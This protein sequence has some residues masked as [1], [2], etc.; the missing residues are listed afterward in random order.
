MRWCASHGELYVLGPC[1]SLHY[2]VRIV[3][4]GALPSGQARQ[5]ATTSQGLEDA[6]SQL[7]LSDGAVGENSLVKHYTYRRGVLVILLLMSLALVL[8]TTTHLGDED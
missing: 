6:S 1:H 5:R 4:R 8:S 7:P 2:W 3:V